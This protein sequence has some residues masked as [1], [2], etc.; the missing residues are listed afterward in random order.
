MYHDL[1]STVA[2]QYEDSHLVNT[3]QTYRKTENQYK[4]HA[5]DTLEG[6]KRFYANSFADA[7][8][9]AS[10][11]LYLGIIGPATLAAR[12]AS[13]N[14]SFSSTAAKQSLATLS[15]VSIASTKPSSNHD[16]GIESET[17]TP[18]IRVVKPRRSYINWFD[19][20]H[21]AS[22]PPFL[23]NSI[24]SK[25]SLYTQLDLKTLAQSLL[26]LP[27]NYPLLL[28]SGNR[29]LR[30]AITTQAWLL[31]TNFPVSDLLSNL[32]LLHRQW[33]LRWRPAALPLMPVA[34][35]TPNYMIIS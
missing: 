4:S 20:E 32:T 1:G 21:R 18:D 11:Y 6:L 16:Q 31:Q 19:P 2:L 13:S 8:K 3:L 9:Q 24:K 7:D 29:L 17:F 22:M 34:S 5:Q 35:S 28:T 26:H 25:I 27:P 33:L 30:L 12:E 14:A 10:I 15:V 23:P